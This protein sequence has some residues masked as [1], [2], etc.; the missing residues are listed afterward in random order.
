MTLLLP[1]KSALQLFH[2]LTESNFALCV[3]RQIRTQAENL[4]SFQCNHMQ[5][6]AKIKNNNILS[7]SH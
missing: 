4:Y 1:D 3:Y 2:L 5:T 6:I 7:R